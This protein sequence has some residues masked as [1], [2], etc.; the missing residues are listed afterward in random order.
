MSQVVRVVSTSVLESNR[1]ETPVNDSVLALD[2]ASAMRTPSPVPQPDALAPPA[3]WA[4]I[5]ATSQMKAKMGP[6]KTLLAGIVA[7]V[8][9]GLGAMLAMTVGGGSPAIAAGGNPGLKM[10]LQGLVGLPMALTIILVC[11]AELWTGNTMFMAAGY[12]GGKVTKEDVATNWAYSY[13]GN[14]IGTTLMALICVAGGC[15]AGPSVE[16]SKAVSIAF[17][18]LSPMACFLKGIVANAIV[19]CAIAIATASRDLI[20]KIFGVLLLVPAFVSM[21]MQHS[22]ANMF[23]IPN[24]MLHGSG[25]SFGAYLGNVITCTLGNMV[26]GVLLAMAYHHLYLAEA[27]PAGALSRGSSKLLN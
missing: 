14:I 20:G 2:P 10:Y 27:K 12:F 3:L 7:G 19:C 8:F 6:K 18:S 15:L 1:A 21:G 4:K 13:L 9:V 17:T 22:I 24:G 26:A 5:E 25:V 16:T 23:L 11:G